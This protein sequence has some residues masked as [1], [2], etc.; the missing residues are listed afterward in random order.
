MKKDEEVA[1][2]C[3][4]II[5]R[6]LK[7]KNPK[8]PKGLLWIWYQ[9]IKHHFVIFGH[10]IELGIL[11]KEIESKKFKSGKEPIFKISTPRRTQQNTT[12]VNKK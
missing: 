7:K 9:D 2:P 10:S 8:I 1:I 3:L 6:E 12:T 4:K 11:F 5:L